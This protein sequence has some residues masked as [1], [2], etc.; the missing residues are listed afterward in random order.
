MVY[1]PIAS[2]TGFY[3]GGNLGYG[4]GGARTD[5]AGSGT[6][7]FPATP[8]PAVG[9]ITT[10]RFADSNTAR[11]NGLIGGGQAGYNVQLNPR[12]IAGLE[13]DIQA[14]GQRGSGASIDP[15]SSPQ[16]SVAVGP[17]PSVCT[18]FS[19]LVGAGVTSYEGRIDWFGTVRG[20]IGVLVTDHLL[21]YGTGG[22]AYGHVKVSDN[23]NL[24]GTILNGSVFILPGTFAA[25]M[26]QFS[27]SET[28]AGWTVG[29]GVEG[30]F[31]GLLPS[32]WTWKLEYLYV[33]LGSVDTLSPFAAIFL[34]PNTLTPNPNLSPL[35]GA[36]TTHTHFRDNI[37]RVGLN[38]QFGSYAAPAVY[39]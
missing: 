33:D 21:A 3:V 27:A 19:N 25:T 20:R 31:S 14:S 32:N 5:V 38:Y 1:A 4:W 10:V 8:T 17:P 2:W 16:C 29:G 39:K 23:T 28:R 11:L 15:F 13:T 18:I 37:V 6:D 24:N 7:S 34:N 22:L 26:T 35:T 30:K 12:W 36:V 9:G